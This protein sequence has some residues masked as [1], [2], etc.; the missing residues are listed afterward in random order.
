MEDTALWHV[1]VND[2]TGQ[3]S[4]CYGFK[5]ALTF[6]QKGEFKT[7][8]RGKTEIPMAEWTEEEL[9]WVMSGCLKESG[10]GRLSD[11]SGIILRA[12]KK[13][14]V[15]EWKREEVL[16]RILAETVGVM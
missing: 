12:M 11:M 2:E 8:G 5:N 15:D 3:R 1:F 14:G 16:R 10:M 6:N 13:C 7:L 9:C 4:C